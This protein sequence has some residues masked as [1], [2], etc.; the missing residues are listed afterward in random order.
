MPARQWLAIAA[1][2]AVAVGA[3]P[4]RAQQ[5]LGHK[6]LG[7]LGLE[8]GAQP[9]PGVYFSDRA[10]F[11]RARELFDRNGHA[12]PV[13]LDLQAF[14]NGLGVAAVFRAGPLHLTTSFGVPVSRVQVN[15][16]RPEASL[17]RFGL[18][19]VYVQPLR[20]GARFPRFDA[21]AS[22]AFYLPTSRLAPGGSGAL[23]QTQWTHEFSLGGAAYFDGERSVRLSLLGS[24]DL[25]QRK[26]D[27]D[28]TRGSTVQ[29]Q[30]GVGKTFLRILEVGLA[31]YALWQVTDDRG[32]ALPA[33][34]RGARDRAFGLGPE[35]DLLVPAI[36]TRVTLRYEHDFGVES[37]PG[38]EILVVGAT[39][40]AWRPESP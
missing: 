28:I 8:A 9:G 33:V 38:G 40:A 29:L 21:V 37:R 15:T 39:V 31:G 22:Y 36:R 6:V 12:L 5:N 26:P 16:A 10:L 25:N 30:G 1:W 23:G 7:T 14:G 2:L 19:D 17:D 4:V 34:L 3:G 13:G 18:G 27:V 32:T 11:Y 20:L 24:Y 35:L